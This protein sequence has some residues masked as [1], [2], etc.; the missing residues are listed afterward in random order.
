MS[1]DQVVNAAVLVFMF[2]VFVV[3]PLMVWLSGGDDFD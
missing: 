1:F 3:V 2:S